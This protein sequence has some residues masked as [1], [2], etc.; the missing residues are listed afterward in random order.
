MANFHHKKINVRILWI[1]DK[2]LFE[3]KDWIHLA[4]NWTTIQFQLFV[5]SKILC[6]WPKIDIYQ[7]DIYWSENEKNGL[8]NGKK[9][10]VKILYFKFELR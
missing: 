7:I 8:N 2:V 5:W 1:K 6:N 9:F 4:K 10:R 3:I